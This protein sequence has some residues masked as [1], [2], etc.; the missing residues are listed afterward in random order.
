MAQDLITAALVFFSLT[1]LVITM[2]GQAGVPSHGG[3]MT[4]TAA[5]VAMIDTGPISVI[6]VSHRGA[7][8]QL[9]ISPKTNI[10]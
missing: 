9:D 5:C 8:D 10:I 3:R 1:P 4:G 7:S 2:A 6:R